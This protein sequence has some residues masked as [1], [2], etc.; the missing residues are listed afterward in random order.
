M[1]QDEVTIG[2]NN[3]TLVHLSGY[4]FHAMPAFYEIAYRKHLAIR[5]SMVK[6]QSYGIGK[7]TLDAPYFLFGVCNPIL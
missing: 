3:I 6:L 2:T 5:V 4:L 7:T 1:V